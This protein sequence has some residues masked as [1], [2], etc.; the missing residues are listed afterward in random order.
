MPETAIKCK[1][2]QGL[3]AA[4]CFYKRSDGRQARICKE[5]TKARAAARQRAAKATPEGRVKIKAAK[6]KYRVSEKGQVSRKAERQKY[7]QKLRDAN[8]TKPKGITEAKLKSFVRSIRDESEQGRLHKDQAW[9]DWLSIASDA[10]LDAHYQSTGKP[11]IDHRLSI[12]KIRSSIDPLFALNNRIAR[13]IR[14]TL[15]R[16]RSLVGLDLGYTNAELM[17]EIESKFLD[18]MSWDHFY[19][20]GKPSGSIHIDHIIPKSIFDMEDRQEFLDC[21][22]LRN[23]QPLWA[24]DNQRKRFSVYVPECCPDLWL[25]YGT[26]ID[27]ALIVDSPSWKNLSEIK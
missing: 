15:Q 18:G 27:P 1:S 2:C 21:W 14:Q 5:C 16:K 6:D 12:Y 4:D 9:R 8:P 13:L 19:S 7:R 26:R 22:S 3:K 17:S 23:L 10:W 25:K 24:E 20:P 11:W